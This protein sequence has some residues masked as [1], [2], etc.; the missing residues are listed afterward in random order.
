[1]DYFQTENP[2]L[3]TLLEGFGMENV[4]IFYDHLE[5]LMPIWYN[6]WQFGIFFPIWYVGTKK[7]LATLMPTRLFQF[8]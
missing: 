6:L 1:M 8:S 5:Y 3:G 2:N 4:F 7:N